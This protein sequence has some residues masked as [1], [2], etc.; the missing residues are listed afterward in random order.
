MAWLG[1]V[2][3]NNHHGWSYHFHIY[4]FVS[5]YIFCI[6]SLHIGFMLVLRND[7]YARSTSE[8]LP[9][10]W[11]FASHI[12]PPKYYHDC[13]LHVCMRVHCF[14]F[15]MC[16]IT[17]ICTSFIWHGMRDKQSLLLIFC[18]QSV[19][20]ITMSSFC[21]FFNQSTE[22]VLSLIAL[23]LNTTWSWTNVSLCSL[24][25]LISAFFT[26]KPKRETTYDYNL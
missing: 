17:F 15:G 8:G 18:Q 24:Q 12:V 7:F 19:T 10:Y 4:S 20:S 16:D 11:K 14:T 5:I 25:I 2:P 1:L 3:C 6:G 22:F 13:V 23:I 26:E 21:F 9:C